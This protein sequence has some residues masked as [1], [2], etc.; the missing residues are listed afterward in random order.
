MNLKIFIKNPIVIWLIA[1]VICPP[2][3][4]LPFFIMLFVYI[5]PIFWIYK[6]IKY[7]R[8]EPKFEAW[9]ETQKSK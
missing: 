4:I 5:H 1:L 3:A 9:L 2:A 8:A 7:L 6:L